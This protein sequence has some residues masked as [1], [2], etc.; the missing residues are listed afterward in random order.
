MAYH[1]PVLASES[2]EALAIRAEGTYVDA[3]F[4]GG[5]QF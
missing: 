2:I 5:G 3:T 1:L 4:G